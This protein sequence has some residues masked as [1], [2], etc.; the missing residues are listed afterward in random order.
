MAESTA[1]KTT[2]KKEE[3]VSPAAEVP[4]KEETR[5]IKIPRIDAKQ[6]DVVVRINDRSWLIKRGVNVE[7]PLCVAEQLRHQEKMLTV[8]YDFIEAKRSSI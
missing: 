8:S 2:T 6:E 3:T 5:I 4:A 1:K 7:V